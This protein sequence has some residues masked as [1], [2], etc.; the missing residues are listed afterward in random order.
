MTL[1]IV[2]T[3]SE[4]LV[5]DVIGQLEEHV[6]PHLQADVSNYAK[7]RQRAWLPYEAPLGASRPW[8]MGV[9]A[10]DLWD[11]ICRT[12][13][14]HNFF[15]DLALASV[16]GNINRHRDA[17]YADYEGWTINLGPCT[18]HYEPCYPEFRWTPGAPQSAPEQTFDLTG[19]ELIQFNVKNPHWVTDAAADRWGI[20]C[21]SV[22]SKGMDGFDRFLAHQ[23]PA[24]APE[25]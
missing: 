10:P 18:Y 13:R 8:Q 19:G 22:S 11:W 15:P 6:R 4:G 7:G 9:Q 17:S 21:W 25:G 20:N 3:L 23:K 16:D 2:Q 14:R 24:A 1:T 5:A 12:L